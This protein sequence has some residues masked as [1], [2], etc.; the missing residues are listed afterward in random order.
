MNESSL[1]MIILSNDTM[2]LP[3]SDKEWEYHSV[4]NM[5]QRKIKIKFVWDYFDLKFILNYSIG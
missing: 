1:V 2:L 3:L 5:E 4:L